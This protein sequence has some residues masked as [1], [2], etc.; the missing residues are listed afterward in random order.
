MQSLGSHFAL[1]RFTA[2]HL[3]AFVRALTPTHALAWIALACCA[4]SV[5]LA[6][7]PAILFTDVESGPVSGGSNN[8]GVP[9][10]IFGKGFG[11]ARGTSSVTIGGVEVAAYNVWGANNANNPTLDMIVVQPGTNVMGGPIVVTVNGE[12]S[13]AN[14]SFRKNDG[15]VLVVATNGSDSNA[16]TE[17]APCATVLRAASGSLSAPGDTILV[18]GGTY[19]ESEIWIRD[20][21][22][23]SG[24]RSERKTIKN[25][26]NEV[27]LF[28]NAARNFIVEA[29]HMT[30][31]GLRF[32]NGKS[33][34]VPETGD[35]TR[36]RGVKFVNLRADGAVS[37]SFLD[38]H[39]DD[40]VLAGCVC[41]ATSSVQGT[42]GHCYYVSYGN[43][44]R[45]IYNIG[46]GAPGY[47]LHI[48]DQRR[49]AGDFTR[50][51][52]NVL[53]EGNI[54]KN[55]KQRSGLILAMGDESALGNRIENVLI[56]NNIFTGN[57]HTGVALGLNIANI[58]MYNNTFY[59]NGR[60]GLLMSDAGPIR[61]V[62]VENNLFY[63]SA[64]DVCTSNCSWYPFGHIGFTPAAVSEFVVNNN[65][66][67]G[68]A[69]TTAPVIWSGVGSNQT[70][71]GATGDTANVTGSVTFENP[72]TF[73]FRIARGDAIDRG[74]DV[75]SAV[76]KDYNGVLRAQGTAL[77]LGAFEADANET[78]LHEC[79]L[80]F[81]GDDAKLAHTDALM[82]LRMTR[83]TNHS[84]ATSNVAFPS[85]ATRTTWPAIRS[86]AMSGSQDIDGDGWRTMNDALIAVRAML[87]FKGDALTEGIAFAHGTERKNATSLLDFLGAR[88]GLAQP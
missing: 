88:C 70:D 61:N 55:S 26:P 87:G 3:R 53:V 35:A 63:Q 71:L 84:S 77:D 66:Y 50:V 80:D 57:N 68:E 48:F 85:G 28:E 18:R 56:R 16:C 54:L 33:I 10:S 44:L 60:Q 34:G 2:R 22:G 72:S 78:P 83:V 74:I 14:F 59:Q 81:D 47:G 67:F 20:I 41:E 24:T 79:K 64:N 8:Q 82:L 12:T 4:S 11:A 75:T 45:L 13:N 5:S 30:V 86:Y 25:H 62:S 6:A 49:K 65:G 39:G 76:A 23:D 58:E 42:Q 52:S 69:R 1:R 51:I 37:W 46:S 38:L 7:P 17:A 21:N 19:A 27:P 36:L 9:I 73:D 40:H 43:N 32:A 31:S 15:K 29:N